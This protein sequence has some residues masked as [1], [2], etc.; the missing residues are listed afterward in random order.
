MTVSLQS[1]FFLFGFF[2]NIIVII[3]IGLEKGWHQK[4]SSCFALNL[5][6]VSISSFQHFSVK[7]F[8]FP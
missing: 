5:D 4:S 1:F 6:T 7:S 8:E 3:T 2:G